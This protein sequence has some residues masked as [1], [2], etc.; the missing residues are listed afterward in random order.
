MTTERSEVIRRGREMIN[1]S[2]PGG[3]RQ[4][5]CLEEAKETGAR[6]SLFL[7]GYKDE[8]TAQKTVL[9]DIYGKRHIVRNCGRI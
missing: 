7:N 6:L 2:M 9:R 3:R 5:L 8:D 1:G 4:R